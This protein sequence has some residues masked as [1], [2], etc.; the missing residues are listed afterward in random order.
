MEAH[1]PSGSTSILLVCPTW[2]HAPSLD[3]R[4]LMGLWEC[5]HTQLGL[6]WLVVKEHVVQDSCEPTLHRSFPRHI[7]AMGVTQSLHK[8]CSNLFTCTAIDH[9]AHLLS[10]GQEHGLVS[11][12]RAFHILFANLSEGS[13]HEGDRLSSY[14]IKGRSDDEIVLLSFI[15]L[16]W[17]LFLVSSLSCPRALALSPSSP[18]ESGQ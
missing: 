8:L 5:H 4:S 7:K 1:L 15:S 18:Q 16:L 17:V 3:S 11:I 10:Q 13:S 2:L 9:F 12:S 14:S 6:K